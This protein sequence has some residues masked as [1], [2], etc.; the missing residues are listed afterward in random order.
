MR[1]VTKAKHRGADWNAAGRE[2]TCTIKDNHVFQWYKSDT[3]VLYAT[4]HPSEEMMEIPPPTAGKNKNNPG[5]SPIGA[6][7]PI[8]F[9][10]AANMNTGVT[11]SNAT[12]G[13]VHSKRGTIE[14]QP[15]IIQ[16]H[17]PFQED[18]DTF[19]SSFY[20][21]NGPIGD[22]TPM[23]R[24]LLTLEGI[25][26]VRKR[27]RDSLGGIS[28]PP[29]TVNGGGTSSSLPK[30]LSNKLHPQ[31]LSVNLCSFDG[32]LK[33][34][35]KLQ[36]GYS[37]PF[38]SCGLRCRGSVG[39]LHQHLVASHPYYEYFITKS[40]DHGAELWVRCRKEW[41]GGNGVFLPASPGVA[42]LT[43]TSTTTITEN[44]TPP[45]PLAMLLHK[46]A[47]SLP[48]QY[49]C[50]E[51]QQRYRNNEGGNYPIDAQ[52][53]R[54]EQR[55]ALMFE[56]AAEA[57][58]AAGV[59]GGAV[60]NP[61]GMFAWET[62][63]L[64]PDIEEGRTELHSG[65]EDSGAGGGGGNAIRK[66]G[67][68][69]ARP[70]RAPTGRQRNGNLAH[71]SRQQSLIPAKLPL[72]AK[73]GLP[74]FYHRGRC[75]AMT[76]KELEI[77]AADSDDDTDTEQYI[78]Y[79]STALEEKPNLCKEEMD[80]MLKWNLYIHNNPIHADSAVPDVCIAFA[81]EHKEMLKDASGWFRR[82]FAAHVLN[83]WKFRL[84][85]PAQMHAAL[86]AA[87]GRQRSSGGGGGGK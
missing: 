31:P 59:G 71:L 27:K 16:T 33:I 73:N 61:S 38:E 85:T 55:A 65:F 74:K 70:P 40:D 60:V 4:V 67:N 34:S 68:A 29:P 49:F 45:H 53:E 79:C 84:L 12:Q 17:D 23:L 20:F 83:L 3:N 32:S 21:K 44:N 22:A 64:T 37:C 43:L 18:G 10:Q 30:Q 15:G 82:C 76:E 46:T 87:G 56:T 9:S 77:E 28:S 72:A 47:T 51:E 19:P 50:R 7:N 25:P 75:I 42:K 80:F 63:D 26:A 14:L 48:F 35:T 81:N 54:I 11:P 69:S 57:A 5:F 41:F 13:G 6:S 78:R 39:A 36:H 8:V 2:V 58:I 86:V 66:G 1:H 52:E 62:A 24:Y